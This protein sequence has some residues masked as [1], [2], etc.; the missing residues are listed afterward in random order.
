MSGPGSWCSSLHLYLFTQTTVQT[1]WEGRPFRLDEALYD[2]THG[3]GQGVSLLQGTS[4]A[5][6]P[7]TVC[8]Y[9]MRPIME[10]MDICLRAKGHADLVS[11]LLAYILFRLG[12][13]MIPPRSIDILWDRDS[14][15]YNPDM[16]S[17]FPTVWPSTNCNA[18]QIRTWMH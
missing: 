3:V 4:T 14:M 11:I 10:C 18:L 17:L 8:E 6:T 2:F 16:E 1:D 12:L 13:G 9:I 7:V 15:F 5:H